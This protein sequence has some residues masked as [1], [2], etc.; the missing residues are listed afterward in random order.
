MIKRYVILV[1]VLLFLPQIIFAQN[2]VEILNLKEFAGFLV[3]VLAY[4]PN[5]VVAAFIFVAAVIINR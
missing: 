1:V 2:R 4:L 5:V 3:N